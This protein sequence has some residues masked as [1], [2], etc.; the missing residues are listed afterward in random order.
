MNEP[1]KKRGVAV[2]AFIIV[3]LLFLVGGVLTIGDLHST[4][5][6]KITVFTI[7]GDVSGLQSGN[8]IWFSGVKIGTVKKIEFYG[9]SQVKVILNIEIDSKKF[10]RK[11]A[12][13]KISTD[14]L[15]GN[16][17][18]VIYG[19]TSAAG[20]VE[21][22]D[23]LLNETSLSTEEIMA[24]F[25][26]TNLNILNLTQK[27]ADGEGTIGKLLNSD[28]V[29]NSINA[30]TT[31]LQAAS[32]NAEAM[33]ASLSGFSA[34]LNKE[35][36]LV[37]DLVTDTVVFG[38]MAASVM[39]LQNVADTAAVLLSDLKTASANPK[40]PVGVLLHD[41]QAGASLKAT[42]GNLETSSKKLDENLEA[43]KS[44]FLLRRY[45]KK[46]EKKKGK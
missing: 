28:S 40:T 37:N 30:A 4:F 32:A 6:R 42:I 13:V 39:Q 14:G 18:L 17:I 45:F 23:E 2:G 46:E 22:G 38:A 25:Q 24:T 27:L 26:Q 35:G 10:I 31:S 16:K 19:G 44:S 9:K 36:T 33:L 41:E 7:F 5:T 15:I 20:E 8:N 11:D 34:K 1:N 43:L 21:E 29:Y 3:G 12:K